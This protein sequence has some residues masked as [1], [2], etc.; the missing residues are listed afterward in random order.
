MTNLLSL[1]VCVGVGVGVN[2]PRYRPLKY[3]RQIPLATPHAAR[4][5]PAV[6]VALPIMLLLMELTCV[7]IFLALSRHSEHIFSS[8]SLHIYIY[9]SLAAPPPSCLPLL[10]TCGNAERVSLPSSFWPLLELVLWLI[11]GS[12]GKANRRKRMRASERER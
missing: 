8:P 6:A 11:F 3:A 4:K 7:K 2:V 12:F 5:T 9:I 1:C 10:P